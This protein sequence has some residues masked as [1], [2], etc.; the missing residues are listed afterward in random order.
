MH[1]FFYSPVL[2]FGELDH[3]TDVIEDVVFADDIT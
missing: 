1:R 2:K 3:K